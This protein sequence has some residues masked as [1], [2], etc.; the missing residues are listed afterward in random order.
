MTGKRFI[1]L[2]IPICLILLIVSLW[3]APA[4]AAVDV[5][6]VVPAPCLVISA[7]EQR[8]GD[9]LL[10][11]ALAAFFDADVHVVVPLYPAWNVHDI[12]LILAIHCESRRDL[13]YIVGLRKEHGWGWGEIAH[14]LGVHPGAFNKQR[15]WAKKDDRAVGEQMLV[16]AIAGY[17]GIPRS[18]VH[19]LR[20][21]SYPVREIALAANLAARSHKSLG[22]VLQLRSAEQSW[23]RIA[24]R[25]GVRPTEL[26]KPVRG[27]G[28]FKSPDEKGKSKPAEPPG[29]GAK[30]GKSKGP[31]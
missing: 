16:R 28:R 29:K 5:K 15:V 2:L 13:D 17:W 25:V 8:A 3:A 7:E 14:H 26:G 31:K 21:R 11:T 1:V 23:G 12:V 6:L 19:A 10:L 22:D 30:T 20:S 9:L 18:H 4:A 24:R 27:K